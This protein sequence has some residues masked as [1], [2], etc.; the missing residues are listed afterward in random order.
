MIIGD[1][2]L[3]F[4]PVDNDSPRHLTRTQIGAFNRDGYVAPLEVFEDEETDANRAY[5]DG[6]LGQLGE[7]G[8]YSI[9]GYQARCR[10][11]WDLGN[12]PRILNLVEDLI[13]P[14]IICWASHF[15]CKLAGDEKIVPWHQD[16]SYWPLSPARTVTVW[17]A[18]DDADDQNAAMQFIPG[19]HT[20]GHLDWQ[21]SDKP[22]VLEQELVGVADLGEPVSN[23]LR[24][25]QISLHADMLA[26][27]SEPNRSDRRRCGLTLRYCPPEVRIVD[28]DWRESTQAII[29]R[30]HDRSNHWVHHD[31]PAD[32]DISL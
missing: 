16:A 26:H 25:G 6:L 9:N 15:F 4:R 14:N 1:R 23:N 27:G 22:A 20:L 3:S 17:L 13:G 21:T 7:R 32:D 24:A 28:P 8:A 31:R 18:I 10:G 30:G 11:I 29:C 12:E 2:D 19:T 5:F